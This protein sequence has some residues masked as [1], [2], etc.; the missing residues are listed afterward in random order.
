MLLGFVIL[1]CL[2][3]VGIFAYDS[4]IFSVKRIDVSGA[5]QLSNDKVS[6]LAGITLGDNIFRVDCERASARL[7]RDAWIRS[8]GVS[9]VYPAIVKIN[10]V[11][12]KPVV[13]LFRPQAMYL[14][15][16]KGFVLARRGP[17]TDAGLPVIRDIDVGPIKV[18]TRI[19]SPVLADC[20]KALMSFSKS[21]RS[22][23]DTIQAP[24]VDKLVFITKE[25]LE[26]DYGKAEDIEAKNEVINK[27]LKEESGKII[28]I[29]VRVV[30]NPTT[31][32]EVR[33]LGGVP[34]N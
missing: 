30:T 12:R 20:L 2:V 28:V 8:A 18:G 25:G 4:S 13:G 17:L 9:R 27:V 21:L 19:N 22:Q 6:Q 34:A 32:P 11:E 7:L 29:D 10:V 1:V 26:I 23:I 16:A 33:K 15:D 31:R 14:L 3:G 5:S 24:A